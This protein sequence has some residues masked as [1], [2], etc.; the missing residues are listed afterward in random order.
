[1]MRV[2]AAIMAVVVGV[3]VM[4]PSASA[5]N[6]GT[7][8]NDLP[9]VDDSTVQNLIS[10]ID[11]DALISDIK[12]DDLV[13][14]LRSE[15]TEGSETVVRLDSDILFAFGKAKL[16]KAAPEQIDNI[17]TDLPRG[18]AVSVGGHTD[19]I[20]EAASN[21]ALSEDRARAVASVIAKARPDVKLT[22]KGFGE[23]KPITPNESGGKDSPEGRA[24][25]R[26]V[27]IRFAT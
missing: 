10:N 9:R 8:I 16:P 6:D 12:I 5:G 21:Q 13:V 25:N 26:R 7:S 23:T 1:M 19:N 17:V 4:I 3:F 18:V 14:D 2:P 20:G 11:L 15:T 24:Q 22:V 27:E